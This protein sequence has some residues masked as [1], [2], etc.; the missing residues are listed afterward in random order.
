LRLPPSELLDTRRGVETPEGVIL[1][2]RPAGPVVRFA[3]FAIDLLI[4]VAVYLILAAVLGPSGKLGVGVMMILL[5]LIEWFYPVFFELRL[6]GATPGKRSM[7]ITVV[8]DSGLPVSAGASITRN[9]LRF[10]DF[11]PLFYGFGIVSMMLTPDFKRLGDLAAG[12]QVVYRE[13]QARARALPEADPIAPAIIPNNEVQQAIIALAERSGRLT[14]ERFDELVALAQQATG[15]RARH[16]ARQR[17]F[18]LAQ[19]LMGKR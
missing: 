2:L 13:R 9:L 8:E 19:W 7:G 15:T 12:T 17:I 11:L 4:R 16:D 3:A 5:F 10:A 14:E 6:G 1:D 18:S